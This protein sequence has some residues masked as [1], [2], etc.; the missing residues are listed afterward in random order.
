LA[1]ALTGVVVIAS[2]GGTTPPAS[3][4]LVSQPEAT[5]PH[6]VVASNAGSPALATYTERAPHVISQ[7]T[8]EQGVQAGVSGAPSAPHADLA[9]VSPASFSA[10]IAAYRVFGGRQ[11]GLMQGQIAQLQHALSAGDR[12]GAQ[13]AW[14][15]AFVDYLKLGAVYLQGPIAGL[16]Q[17]IDGNSGGLVGGSASPRFSG[18]HRLELGLWT[19]ERLQS[20]VPWA[21]RLR[22][23]VA[24]LR[25]L[26]PHVQIAPLDYA[27]RAHEILEDAVRDLLSGTDVP[28]SGEGVLGTAAGIDATSEVISTLRPLLIPR[29]AV[30]PAV[31]AQLRVLQ[32]AMASI[33]AAH[34]GR[35]PTNA[36]LTQQQSELLNS[37]IGGALEALAQVPGALEAAPTPATAQIPRRSARTDP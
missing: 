2:C 32:A 21:K 7:L 22:V 3:H 36:Q 23:D 10:P 18:L 26:L 37:A 9:P 33:K 17:A 12:T 19:G 24:R 1:L 29:D 27:T 34:G 35:L 5:Q 20:L 28:W 14:R 13:N 31:D 16:N 11:L 25:V 8:L 15:D 4:R 6:G 30:L